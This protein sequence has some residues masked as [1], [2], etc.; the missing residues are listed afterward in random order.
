[1]ANLVNGN[2]LFADARANHYAIGAYNINNLEW[3]RAILKGAQETQ[4]PVLVQVSMGLRVTWVAISLLRIWLR[5]KLT[6]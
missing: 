1:M 4:T 3:T 2:D 5:T 6:R